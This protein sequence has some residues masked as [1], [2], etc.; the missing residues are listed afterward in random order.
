M[1]HCHRQMDLAIVLYHRTATAAI[2]IFQVVAVERRLS[3]SRIGPRFTPR[4]TA[5]DTSYENYCVITGLCLL[6]SNRVCWLICNCAS[7]IKMTRL[8]YCY[9]C[10]KA[11]WASDC[12]VRNPPKI[13]TKPVTPATVQT[14]TPPVTTTVKVGDMWEDYRRIYGRTGQPSSE[15]LNEIVSKRRHCPTCRCHPR[16][17]AERQ[18]AYR[19]RHKA[20]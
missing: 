2:V 10:R 8:N 1:G 16:T 14:V 11:H 18:R 4:W 6:L 5:N 15:K 12:P 13:V 9:D 20:Q 19:Q 7:R 17:N 3:P